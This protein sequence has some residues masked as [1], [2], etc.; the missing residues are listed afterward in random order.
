LTIE[1]SSEMCSS[2]VFSLN[3]SVEELDTSG[4]NVGK[5][6][7]TDALE[8]EV[9][10]LLEEEEFL[11]PSDLSCLTTCDCPSSTLFLAAVSA[12]LI[13]AI[14]AN[15]IACYK[16][17]AAWNLIV[18]QRRLDLP[19]FYKRRRRMSYKEALQC[20][21]TPECMKSSSCIICLCDFFENELVTSCDDGCKNWF[22]KEC[23]FEWLDRSEA[24]PC[25]RKDMLSKKSRGFFGD[26]SACMGFPPSR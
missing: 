2:E 6:F 1:A 11:D 14:V 13:L 12:Y 23:L 22:H 4:F 19:E 17:V 8:D 15:L 9:P 21:V 25:C 3:T 10:L 24:C 5:I 7:F 16:F 20:Q 26:L 18:A